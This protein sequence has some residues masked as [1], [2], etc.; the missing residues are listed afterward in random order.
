MCGRYTHNLTWAEIRALAGMAFPVPKDNPQPD[1]NVAPTEMV[2][3]VMTDQHHV[4]GEYAR[5]DFIPPWWS[6]DLTD[7]KFSTFKARVEE[8]RQ[9]KTYN[10][11]LRSHRCLVPATAFYEWKRQNKTKHPFAVG[12]KRQGEH[13]FAPFF[14]AGIWSHWEGTYKAVRFETYS[15]TILT[16][17]A[18][19]KIRQIH[20]REPAI[21]TPDE[22]EPWL[23]APSVEILPRINQAL[24]SQLLRFYPVSDA[25]DNLA[26]KGPQLLTP[27]DKEPQKNARE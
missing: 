3:V 8:I 2:P 9:K 13:G 17:A 5:W 22:Y 26:S 1:Y 19:D 12:V 11:A 21:L 15:V 27:I 24:P 25:V 6:Q 20:A 10:G 4:W 14:M 23:Y 7:K 16:R 18:G